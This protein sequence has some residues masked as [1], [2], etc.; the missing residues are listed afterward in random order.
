MSRFTEHLAASPLPVTLTPRWGPGGGLAILFFGGAGALM[1][2][3]VIRA[4]ARGSAWDDP[5]L[6]YLAAIGLVAL[7]VAAYFIWTYASRWP[8]LRIGAGRVEDIN[9]FGRHEVLELGEHARVAIV[10]AVKRGYHPR[11]EA[12]PMAPG[13]PLRVIQLRPFLRNRR[14]AAALEALIHRAAG[15]RPAPDSAQGALSRGYAVR[16]LFRGLGIIALFIGL[17][18]VM[19]RFGF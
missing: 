17:G 16:D 9:S 8:R 18:V 14:E 6:L 12:A 7:G 19:R 15:P 2:G 1:E 10:T 13:P 11:L 3:M 5:R 4:L